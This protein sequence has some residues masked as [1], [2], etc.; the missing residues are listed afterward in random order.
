MHLIPQSLEGRYLYMRLYQE[1]Y[2]GGY[3]YQTHEAY[4]NQVSDY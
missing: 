4:D 2:P 3:M 1:K